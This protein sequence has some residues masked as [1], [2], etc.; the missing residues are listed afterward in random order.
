MCEPQW[1]NETSSLE[2]KTQL[3]KEVAVTNNGEDYGQRQLELQPCY[4]G[5]PFSQQSA[6]PK[7]KII[8]LATD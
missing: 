6:E 5:L 3:K 2:W 1:K 7:T 8:F 4:L